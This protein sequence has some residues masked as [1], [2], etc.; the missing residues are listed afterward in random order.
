MTIER[1][2][3]DGVTREINRQD[4][5]EFYLVFL[6]IQH[7]VL[8]DPIRVVSDTKSF[9]LKDAASTARTYL[10]YKFGIQLLSDSE[11]MPTAKLTI[12]NVDRRIGKA[13]QEATEPAKL[14]IEVVAGSEFDLTV[15]PRVEVSTAER[16]YVAENLTLFDV[17]ANPLQLTGT[18]R[19]WDYTQ[20]IWPGTR[21]TQDRFPG[22][23]R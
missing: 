4:S 15:D 16:I 17:E 2:I 5:P 20:E 7:R 23:F 12:Q 22:L 11:N 9:V 10:P 21:A 13:I 8:V 3:P 14:M 19:S 18:L 6:T 1:T